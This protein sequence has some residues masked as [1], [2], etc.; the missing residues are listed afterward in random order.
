[1]LSKV[2]SDLASLWQTAW[3][4]AG[5]PSP[6]SIQANDHNPEIYYLAGAYPN[7]FNP[8]TTIDWQSG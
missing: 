2:K 7:P 8:V 3:E 5:N 4:N 6:A 1:M